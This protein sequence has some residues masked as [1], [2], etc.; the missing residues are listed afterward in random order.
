MHIITKIL[1]VTFINDA[2]NHRDI[3]V[4]PIRSEHCESK[5][6]ATTSSCI[7]IVIQKVYAHL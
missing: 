1:F 2:V 7:I 5:R 4:A 3:L 6:K